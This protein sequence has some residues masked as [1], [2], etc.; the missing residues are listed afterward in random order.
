MSISIG[1]SLINTII[2]WLEEKLFSDLNLGFERGVDYFIAVFVFGFVLSFLLSF[3]GI[4]IIYLIEEWKKIQFTIWLHLAIFVLHIVAIFLFF[5]LN[6]YTLSSFLGYE[7]TG[8]IVYYFVVY[9][10]KFN[11]I[12][13]SELID[14]D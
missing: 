8:V 9:K 6:S 2:W 7:L 4:F 1:G 10:R 5:D 12:N 13:D 14:L 11:N 3:P